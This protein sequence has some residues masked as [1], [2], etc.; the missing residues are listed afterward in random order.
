[1]G[2]KPC[3]QTSPCL[4]KGG[5]VHRPNMVMNQ[6]HTSTQQ[7]GLRAQQERSAIQGTPTVK[8]KAAS[9]PSTQQHGNMRRCTKKCLKDAAHAPRAAHFPPGPGW[10]GA[11]GQRPVNARTTAPPLTSGPPERPTGRLMVN[12]RRLAWQLLAGRGYRRP[13]VACLFLVP[14]TAPLSIRPFLCAYLF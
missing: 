13:A 6:Q 14:R 11:V 5:G 7:R 10:D 2:G 8:Q 12:R 4:R 3:A 1:M 9:V